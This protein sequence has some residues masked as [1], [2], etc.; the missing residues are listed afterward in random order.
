VAICDETGIKDRITAALDAP[1]RRIGLNGRDLVPVLSGF[2][3]NVVAVF[4]SRACS[5]CTRQSCVSLIAF[6]SA[7]SYQIGASLSLFGS[8]QAPWLFLPYLLLLFVVGA[9]HTRLWHRALA[10]GAAPD[11]LL[12]RVN[13]SA[14]MIAWG[15][16]PFGAAVGGL[17][18]E[19]LDIRTA[20]LIMA[21]GVAVSAVLGWFSPL[22][23]HAGAPAQ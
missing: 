18:A 2:G 11:H 10:A 6:G 8:A 3:C 23:A 5:R 14:R 7:C 1:L 17:L 9:I 16:A 19:A 15:G 13:V 22:R 12:S 20:Y 4:Q 21:I